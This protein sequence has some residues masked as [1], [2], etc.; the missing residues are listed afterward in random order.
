MITEISMANTSNKKRKMSN[1]LPNPNNILGHQTTNMNVDDMYQMLTE[2]EELSQEEMKQNLRIALQ[3]LTMKRKVIQRLNSVRQWSYNQERNS[4]FSSLTCNFPMKLKQFKCDIR[5]IKIIFDIWHSHLKVIQGHFGTAVTSYFY[6]LRWLF[7]LNLLFFLLPLCFIIIPQSL[8][9][10]ENINQSYYRFKGY[11]SH[12]LMYYGYYTNET[13]G[14][15]SYNIPEAYI[16]SMSFYFILWLIISAYSLAHAYQ[17]NFVEMFG[18]SRNLFSDKIFS[19]WDFT[20]ETREAA[21]LKSR[22]IYNNL[23]E[24]LSHHRKQRMFLI[25][26]PFIYVVTRIFTNI[27]VLI[28]IGS[29]GYLTHYLLQIKALKS[30]IQFLEEMA[31]SLTIT[32][33]IFI[34]PMFFIFLSKY[35][36]KD[37]L[38]QLYITMSRIVLLEVIILGVVLYFW[39]FSP[40]KNN[41]EICWETMLGEEIT[42]LLIVNFVFVLIFQI[43]IGEIFKHY[44]HKHFPKLISNIEFNIAWNTLSLIYTQTLTWIGTFYSPMLP[45]VTL[46]KLLIIFYI[47]RYSIFYNCKPS[48]KPWQ[49]SN[50][51]TVFLGLTFG[52]LIL[53]LIAVT[54]TVFNMKPSSVC[55]PF[56]HFETRYETILQI[57]NN[58]GSKN[59]F[60]VLITILLSPGFF[61]VVIILF[62]VMVYLARLKAEARKDMVSLLKEHINMESKDKAFL[63]KLIEKASK[64]HKQAYHVPFKPKKEDKQKTNEIETSFHEATSAPIEVIN[65]LY[66]ERSLNRNSIVEDSPYSMRENPIYMTF[67]T[68]SSPDHFNNSRYRLIQKRPSS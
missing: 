55:G 5:D 37:K 57:I 61:S 18:R 44:L 58:S 29:L 4:S 32:T 36:I 8:H 20:I 54:Y 40:D 21:R 67:D 12:T 46:I 22:S 60:E 31:I 3:N 63:L 26:N 43:I 23:L 17:S 68:E 10:V 51:H 9:P 53:V 62:C 6:F 11:F 66:Q 38:I 2:N 33:I 28:T 65:H 7:I 41:D 56:K 27:I 52:N 39:F 13:I 42:R 64:E 45:V 16:F 49:A 47:K 34:V 24:E 19:G 48:V 35:E 1:Q 50:V 15:I 59:I 14:S 30:N 25:E